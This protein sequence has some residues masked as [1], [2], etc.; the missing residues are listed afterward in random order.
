MPITEIAKSRKC[1]QTS[2]HCIH[3]Y[4][5]AL[6]Q[7]LVMC[8]LKPS[9]D[10]L[11]EIGSEKATAVVAHW[12]HRDAAYNTELMS[13]ES[14]HELA[15]RFVQEFSDGTSRF[16]TNGRWF[17]PGRPQ[18]WEPF[19]DSVFDGGLLI[20]SGTGNDTQHICIWFEDED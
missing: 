1:G 5:V 8:R 10:K 11:L 3:Q 15:E 19:T 18:S 2:F 7:I 16:F 20:A 13:A 14:A 6:D 9:A 17:E 12:L 4:P